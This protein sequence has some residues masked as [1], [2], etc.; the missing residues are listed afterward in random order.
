MSEIAIKLPKEKIVEGLSNL[1]FTEIKELI[2]LLIEN[3]LFQPP[4]AKEIYKQAS[5]IVKNESLPKEVAEE[6]VR[7][8]RGR[9]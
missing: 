3:R 9:K 1:S 4:S 5:Q 8:A 6:A 7:W 2:D